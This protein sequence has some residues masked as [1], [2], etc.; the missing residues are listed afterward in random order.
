MQ[1]G[2][3]DGGGSSPAAA[4]AAVCR[5]LPTC[6][7]SLNWT[8]LMLVVAATANQKHQHLVSEHQTAADSSYWFSHSAYGCNA[9]HATR[10]RQ[11]MTTAAIER[12]QCWLYDRRDSTE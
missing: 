3:Y 8:P 12:Y 6:V 4:T 7:H 2:Y 11:C 9:F 1:R 5:Q 10:K